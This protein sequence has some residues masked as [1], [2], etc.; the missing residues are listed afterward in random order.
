MS[1]GDLALDDQHRSDL[2]T[3]IFETLSSGGALV[4]IDLQRAVRAH[5][6][7]P[8]LLPDLIL[9][10][11]S[12]LHAP[13]RRRRLGDRLLLRLRGKGK[14]RK[15]GE[16]A[17]DHLRLRWRG[18][19]SARRAARD[20]RLPRGPEQYRRWS[21]APPGEC[22]WSARRGPA[23]RSSPCHS[24]RGRRRL[25]HRLASRVRR[26]ARRG[27]G[28]AHPRPLCQARKMAPAIVFIDEL[29]AAGAKRGA[30]V[31]Q[32]NDEREQTPRPAAGRDGTA[33]AA[34][35]AS[36]SWARPNRR[37]PRPRPA[38]RALRSSGDHRRPRRAR[39][40]K[41]SSCTQ[42][43]LR[44]EVD[45]LEIAKLCPGFSGAELANL[46]NEERCY[47][48]RGLRRDRPGNP[49]GGDRR[50]WSPARRRRPTS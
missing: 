32:G 23:R 29:D 31:G 47:G 18:R 44:A 10:C 3:R 19:G 36:S 11:L 17:A 46:V 26:V 13:G 37:H 34:M 38:R 15:K 1:A 43:Q 21:R 49:G 50:G 22:S 2:P 41:S 5:P 20:P 7:R 8:D 30:G 14:R 33:S 48:P 16:T 25:L 6:R 35:P 39:S 12:L 24:R 9:V 28:C 40:M 4:S 27:R 42:G 45:L